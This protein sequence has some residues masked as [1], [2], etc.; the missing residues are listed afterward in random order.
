M[1]FLLIALCFA[2]PSFAFAGDEAIEARK[3]WARATIGQ[4]LTTAVYGILENTTGKDD[5]LV[6]VS[7]PMARMSQIHRTSMNDMGIMKMEHM[8]KVVLKND[9]FVV[10]EPGDIHIMLMGLEGKLEKGFEIPLKLEF[11]NAPTMQLRVP[12]YA[13]TTKFSDVR[14]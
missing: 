1:R 3:F 8:E 13:A 6:S 9:T 5:A 11:E 14:D 10:M 7:T 4:N 2:M 12:V